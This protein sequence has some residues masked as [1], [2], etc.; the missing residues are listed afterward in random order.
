[1]WPERLVVVDALPMASGGKVAKGELRDDIR[2]RL[3]EEG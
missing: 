1:M 2:R 3:A